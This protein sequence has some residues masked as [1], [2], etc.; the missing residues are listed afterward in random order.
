MHDLTTVAPDQPGHLCHLPLK[1]SQHGE[2]ERDFKLGCSQN[3][4]VIDRLQRPFQR[5][6]LSEKRTFKYDMTW[7]PNILRFELQ[8]GG[9]GAGTKTP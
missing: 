3:T 7:P 2:S 5:A 1:R 9:V 6:A 4:H 8:A